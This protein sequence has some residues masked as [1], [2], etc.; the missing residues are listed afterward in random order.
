M[1]LLC[2]EGKRLDLWVEM[3]GRPGG[4]ELINESFPC[5]AYQRMQIEDGSFGI[6]LLSFIFNSKSSIKY[7]IFFSSYFCEFSS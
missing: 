3:R 2:P 4:G 1:Y 6:G 7:V 5:N